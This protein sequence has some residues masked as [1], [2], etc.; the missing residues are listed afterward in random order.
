MEATLCWRCRKCI[1][2]RE[3]DHVL[4]FAYNALCNGTCLDDIEL[5][6]NVVVFLDASRLT[7]HAP[8]PTPHAPRPTRF[9]AG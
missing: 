9:A 1:T 2:R 6:R 3:S 7:P 8:R 5:R 4:N